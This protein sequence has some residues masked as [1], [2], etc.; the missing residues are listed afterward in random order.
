MVAVNK[1]P[2][3]ARGTIYSNVEYLL[4]ELVEVNKPN[5]S[6]ITSETIDNNKI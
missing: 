2:T 5:E 6:N 4:S 1:A 3:T